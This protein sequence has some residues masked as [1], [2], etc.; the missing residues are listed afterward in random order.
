MGPFS[1]ASTIQN[2]GYH[3]LLCLIMQPTTIPHQK[4]FQMI[5]YSDGARAGEQAALQFVTAP[6]V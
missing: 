2:M 4:E 5:D 3:R 6:V 1:R